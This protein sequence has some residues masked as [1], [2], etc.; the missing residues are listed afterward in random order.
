M[1]QCRRELKNQYGGKDYD[2]AEVNH[3]RAP[4]IAPTLSTTK[5]V[6]TDGGERSHKCRLAAT[7]L[8]TSIADELN[9]GRTRQRIVGA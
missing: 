4:W 7:P 9:I 6:R 8:R 5:A 2:E 1:P 3:C